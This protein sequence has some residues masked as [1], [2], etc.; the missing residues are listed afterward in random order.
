MADIGAE[1]MRGK[2]MEAIVCSSSSTNNQP[3]LQGPDKGTQQ[4]EEE[5]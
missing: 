5:P 4:Q 2:L 1:I 3:M